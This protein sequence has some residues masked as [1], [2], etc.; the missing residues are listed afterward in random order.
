MGTE[1]D[2]NT[3]TR[4]DCDRPQIEGFGLCA[5]HIPEEYTFEEF[6]EKAAGGEFNIVKMS[7]LAQSPLGKALGLTPPDPALL[8]LSSLHANMD[9]GPD[10]EV[11]ESDQAREDHE[12]MGA[13]TERVERSEPTTVLTDLRDADVIRLVAANLMVL[14]VESGFS[15][16]IHRDENPVAWHLMEIAERVDMAELGVSDETVPEPDYKMADE[17]RCEHC[18]RP[19][20]PGATTCCDACSPGQWYHTGWCDRMK[21]KTN[22]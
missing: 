9:R 1:S 8:V 13:L 19:R 18:S 22:E 20:K 2:K 6:V 12:R 14:A 15:G 3:C 10:H 4:D 11:H 16:C 17:T 7:E 21:G 5:G